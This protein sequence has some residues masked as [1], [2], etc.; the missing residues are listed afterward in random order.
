MSH[1]YFLIVAM[2]EFT[3]AQTVQLV[4]YAEHHRLGAE[5]YGCVLTAAGFGGC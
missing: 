2:V 3:T 4:V 5:G 1:R